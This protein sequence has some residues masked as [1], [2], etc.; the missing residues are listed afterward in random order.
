[1][2]GVG[3]G[4]RRRVHNCTTTIALSSIFFSF[5]VHS[6]PPSGSWFAGFLFCFT[7]FPFLVLA[8]FTTLPYPIRREEKGGCFVVLVVVLHYRQDGREREREASKGGR[9]VCVGWRHEHGVCVCFALCIESIIKV[10]YAGGVF[11]VC[12][13]FCRRGLGGKIDLL[14]NLLTLKS[15]FCYLTLTS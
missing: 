13:F 10:F 2:A 14:D 9:C 6:K 11:K 15:W 7:Y 5:S 12:M 4:L 3:L 1:M 8:R